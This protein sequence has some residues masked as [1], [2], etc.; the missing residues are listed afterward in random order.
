MKK[1]IGLFLMLVLLLTT[2]SACN[3]QKTKQQNTTTSSSLNMNTL[4]GNFSMKVGNSLEGETILTS[5][6]FKGFSYKYN[7]KQ[8]EYQITLY[9][10]SDGQKIFSEKTKELIGQTIS[11]WLSN[12]LIV[13]P[14]VMEQINDSSF[15]FTIN[16]SDSEMQVLVKK[17]QTK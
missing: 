15:V 17:L 12:E 14:K 7:E 16:K 5:Q 6:D 4:S 11:V 2:I 1:Y 10:T 9:F 3:F 13:S 8:S